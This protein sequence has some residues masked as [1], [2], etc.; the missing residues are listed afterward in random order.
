MSCG[1]WWDDGA[2]VDVEE[3]LFYQ[4]WLTV[5][6]LPAPRS[7]MRSTLH[8][9]NWYL[10]GQSD[11]CCCHLNELLHD[12]YQASKLSR[13]SKWSLVPSPSKESAWSLV[14]FSKL[15]EPDST[16]LQFSDSHIY[17]Y[18]PQSPVFVSV[19]QDLVALGQYAA[20]GYSHDSQR[21][22]HVGYMPDCSSNRCVVVLPS[23][24]GSVV[25]DSAVAG[26]SHHC[27]P[28]VF[29]R[30]VVH[31]VTRNVCSIESDMAEQ[32]T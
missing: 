15:R 28:T 6:S 21:W 12:F 26:S 10:L 31:A 3:V 20:Y 18:I 8:N 30:Y 19:G 16:P 13:V 9:G 25:A 7:E 17:I 27:V 4:H 5:Q 29:E 23:G 11:M 1:G 22:L 14:R 2:R 24:R 32:A